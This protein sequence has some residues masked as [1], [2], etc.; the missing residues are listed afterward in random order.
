M[1]SIYRPAARFSPACAHVD[2]Q[3]PI[4]LDELAYCVFA[5]FYAETCL[6]QSVYL[7]F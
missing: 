2:E 5:D 7:F 3:K 4:F 1:P 6:W